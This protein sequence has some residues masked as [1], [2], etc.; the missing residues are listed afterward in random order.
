VVSQR[1]GRAIMEIRMNFSLPYSTGIWGGIN[2]THPPR[3]DINMGVIKGVPNTLHNP[4]ARRDHPT[5]GGTLLSGMFA[6]GTRSRPQKRHTLASIQ[7]VSAQYGHFLTG[8]QTASLGR[9]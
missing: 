9:V 7:I 6:F 8:C 4:D 3:S 5:V 1:G 2:I